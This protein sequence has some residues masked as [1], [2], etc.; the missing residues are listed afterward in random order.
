[1]G[2]SGRAH[3]RAIGI[4]LALIALGGCFCW[5]TGRTAGHVLCLAALISFM[6]G[7][8]GVA[9][10]YLP[11]EV[12]K[13]VDCLTKWLSLGTLLWVLGYYAWQFSTARYVY[14]YDNSYYY[15]QQAVLS[16]A[17]SQ[18]GWAMLQALW[19][20][21]GT[22]YTMLINVLMA[23]LTP[24]TGGQIQ[25]YAWF[26]Q[27]ITWGPMLLLLR[28][29]ALRTGAALALSPARQTAL[30]GVLCLT[31]CTLPLMHMAA[32]RCQQNLLGLVFL[33]EIIALTLP[34]REC[35]SSG[36]WATL[37]LCAA[38][39]AYTRRWFV[40]FLAGYL[41]LWAALSLFRLVKRR[42]FPALRGFVLGLLLS[43][44]A[45]VALLW[46][47]LT[48]AL[49]GNYLHTYQY[50]NAG[51][52]PFE[53]HNQWG[54]I[55]TLSLLDMAGGG[56]WACFQR[57][58]RRLRA[59]ALTLLGTM[60]IALVLFTRIQ[61]MNHHQSTLL[62]PGYVFGLWMAFAA[63]LTLRRRILGRFGLTVVC[64][65]LLS[66]YGI[67]LT[68]G[69]PQAISPL[70]ANVSLKPPVHANLRQVRAVSAFIGSHCDAA[71]P[72]LV[73]ANNTWYD[74][75]VFANALFPDRTVRAKI[76]VTPL[77]QPQ[78]G[79]PESWF[80]ASCYVAPTICKTLRPDDTLEKLR[81][82]AL[83]ALSDR[84]ETVEVLPCEGFELLILKRKGP[85]QS[86]EAKLLLEAF[87]AEDALY[88]NLYGAVIR[89]YCASPEAGG[90]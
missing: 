63:L 40:F 22:D 2:V 65:L 62:L 6:G 69:S 30:Y 80:T 89:P 81:Q 56:A 86:D 53:L 41:P 19:A 10:R 47:L 51:G 79:F 57:R 38:L 5:W 68:Q 60:L 67:S 61:N 85:V 82:L 71:H 4:P 45:G 70:L 64:V 26:S 43:A 1:M 24:L 14:I 78:D 25:A 75:D 27:V 7:A 90:A 31:L 50:W 72:A 49:A 52:L 12:E 28:R 54:Y 87:A 44:A 18:G 48:H 42:N 36:H 34:G 55:G 83:G 88:P 84:F 16:A 58:D 76:A 74:D 33:L 59:F 32:S 77:F 39:L 15:E 21:L 13:R 66:Q 73:L 37:T 17:L 3:R 20:S 11:I 29:L 23:P 35:L 46:P 9:R 8:A